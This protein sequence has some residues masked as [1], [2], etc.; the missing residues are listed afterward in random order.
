MFKELHIST[1]HAHSAVKPKLPGYFSSNQRNVVVLVDEL[2]ESYHVI[3]VLYHVIYIY[4]IDQLGS[5]QTYYIEQST[6][7]PIS[8]QLLSISQGPT[9][10]DPQFFECNLVPSNT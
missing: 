2:N 3:P 7:T 4:T 10:L 5:G 8:L 1:R 6:G 9:G